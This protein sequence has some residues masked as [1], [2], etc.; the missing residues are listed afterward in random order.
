MNAPVKAKAIAT[1][2]EVDPL[3]KL[4]EPFP[5]HQIS[6]LPKETKSQSEQR[7][8]DQEQ[9]K[10]PAKCTVCGGLH[11]PKA[12][13][14]DYVGHAALTDRL[15]D[16]DREW[17]WEPAAYRDGL[18]AFDQTGGLWIKLTV[19]GVTRLGYGHAATK[20]GMDPGSREK[21]VIGDAL[22]NAAMR[23][24][25]AL[26]LW[27][28]GDLHLAEGGSD[29]PDQ[30]ANADSA[31]Q[32]PRRSA[33]LV[34]AEAAIIMC[35]TVEACD[36]W[37]ADNKAMLDSIDDDEVFNAIAKAWKARR[38]AVAPPKVENRASRS[39]FRAEELEGALQ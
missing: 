33:V 36:K 19:C 37:K 7:K 23:F 25:A 3:A 34:A 13:H 11:H 26:D 38:A 31:P 2:V 12:V 22:R 4:R 39:D 6:K 8:K 21:E 29:E 27:H 24:G 14:L 28:K 35:D 20:P 5:A 9:G 30:N 10:W 1:A 16:T 15:L 17:S 32:E 18:P